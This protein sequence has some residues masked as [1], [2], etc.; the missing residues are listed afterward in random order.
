MDARAIAGN[1]NLLTAWLHLTDHCNLRCAYCYLPHSP[2][3]MS[4]E[5]GRAAIDAT[6]R[7][8]LSHGYHKVKFKYAGGEPLL[9]FNLALALHEYALMLGRQYRVV[10]DGVVLSNGVLLNE[11]RAQILK[12]NGL[13]L[14]ISLDGMEADHDAQRHYPDGRGSFHDVAKAIDAA[15]ARHLIPGIS[16]TVSGRNAAGLPALIRWLLARDL[17]FNI[18]FYRANDLS[19][20]ETLRL[21]D[22]KII[23]GM[24]AAFEVIA[25]DL[26]RHSI[27][28]M[29][30][31]RANLF[32]PHHRTCGVGND[33]LAFNPRGGVAKCQMQIERSVGSV[34]LQ[35]PLE[36][37]R[38]DTSGIQNLPVE[39]KKE[40]NQCS[41]RY[42]CAGGCPLETHRATG[43]YDAKSPN[44]QIYQALF[45]KVLKLEGMRL[46]QQAANPSRDMETKALIP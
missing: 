9:Q 25:A 31:D 28:S 18:N 46:L 27:L 16:I 32:A 45:P 35:D 21:D 17:P 40:C 4:L 38:A 23:E 33:Y 2:V 44:C 41:W 10:V 8:A 19:N 30:L 12:D 6:F 29:L 11:K 22:E 1:G 26:P 13:R 39:S 36:A 15:L 7:S 5:T 37:V 34:H 42:W 3:N 43:R 14:M 20:S 24:N